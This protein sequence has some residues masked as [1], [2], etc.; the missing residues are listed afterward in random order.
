MNK[1]IVF[2][3]SNDQPM[4]LHLEQNALFD[5]YELR[6]RRRKF[7]HVWSSL[8][9]ISLVITLIYCYHYDASIVVYLY[10]HF[11]FALMLALL[12]YKKKQLNQ[13]TAVGLIT[14]DI[15][16]TRQRGLYYHDL[17]FFVFGSLIAFICFPHAIA[18]F[19]IITFAIINPTKYLYHH[20]SSKT[21]PILFTM[22][23][24]FISLVFGAFLMLSLFIIAPQRKHKVSSMTNTKLVIGSLVGSLCSG[25]IFFCFV[26]T[27]TSRRTF[28][29]NQLFRIIFLSSLLWLNMTLLPQIHLMKRL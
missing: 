8:F 23:G 21:E 28:S 17:I 13:Q 10:V 3:T 4:P 15:V 2:N 7:P 1:N 26:R 5:T 24:I 16:Y 25:I 6:N 19:S 20:F 9:N 14:E 11:C 27:T 12:E 29:E 18:L 22:I